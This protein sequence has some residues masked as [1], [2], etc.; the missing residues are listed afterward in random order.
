MGSPNTTSKQYNQLQE[1]KE[2]TIWEA[3]IPVLA[4]SLI[5]I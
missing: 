2:L 5:H 3:L 4:L 1:T